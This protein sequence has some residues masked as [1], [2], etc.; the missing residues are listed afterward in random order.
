VTTFDFFRKNYTFEQPNRFSIMIKLVHSNE[1]QDYRDLDREAMVWVTRLTS[2]ESSPEDHERFRHWRDQS[3]MHRQALHQARSVWHML[4]DALPK[5]DQLRVARAAKRRRMQYALPLAAS[6]LLMVGLNKDAFSTWQ[7]DLV[8]A[9][10]EQRALTLSDGSRIVMSGN[11]AVDLNFQKGARAIELVRG[12]VLFKVRHDAKRAFLV[13]AGDGTYRDIG[14]VFSIKRRGASSSIVVSEGLVQAN[15]GKTTALISAGQ[16]MS[17]A[18]GR[19]G[20]VRGFNASSE[21]AWVRGRLIFTDQSLN[22][23]FAALDPHYAGHVIVLN[24]NVG[25]V[26]LSASIELD[27]VDE[28]LDALRTTNGIR[29]TR[30]GR[31]TFLT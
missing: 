16:A 13:R 28:W 6:L 20:A 15:V 4:G 17:I 2:G 3:E 23:I 19:L 31:F 14:T 9:A 10:G 11:S 29:V 1:Q 12:E 8:T 21:L 5:V 26:R 22:E 18:K 25:R 24:R 7:Y 30:I 27:H